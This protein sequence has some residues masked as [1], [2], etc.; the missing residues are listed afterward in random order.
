MQRYA[1]LIQL[2]DQGLRD[3]KDSV[4]RATE[5]RATVEAAGGRVISLYWAIGAYDGLV[6][7]DTPDEQTATTLLLQ[8]ART[9]FV[10]TKT[11]RIYETE[12]FQQIAGQI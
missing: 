1:S 3:I 10:R 12:E 4:H 2:T 6:V 8:L 7:M 9:G 5:F 11:L